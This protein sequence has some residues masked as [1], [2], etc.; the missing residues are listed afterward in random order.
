M[1]CS[2][3]LGEYVGTYLE[4]D[5][6]VHHF[7]PDL[8]NPDHLL[9][10][11]GSSIRVY[12]EV[13]LTTI[14]GSPSDFGYTEGFGNRKPKAM[15]NS[16]TSFVQLNQYE[17]VL[18]DRV[19]HCVRHVNRN[20]TRTRGF[21]GR[22]GS[23]GDV[24]GINARFWV[25]WGIFENV[26]NP[27]QLLVTDT[28][29]GGVK[30]IDKK[31]R[32]VGRLLQ[33]KRMNKPSGVLQTPNGIYISA[34]SGVHLF[35][36]GKLLLVT[37]TTSSKGFK[38]GLYNVARY[39]TLR[40]MIQLNKTTIMVADSNNHRVRV[41]DNSIRNVSS[42]CNGDQGHVDEQ[43]KTCSLTFV[44]SLLAHKNTLFIGEYQRI[45]RVQGMS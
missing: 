30:T 8:L 17:I 14:I 44:Y 28:G 43:L 21:A 36:K 38:D 23:R 24:E 19:N 37:G 18:V 34:E 45:R 12:D 41:L 15:F 11:D 26:N 16:I 2:V 42:I 7:E 9:I 13:K 35:L 27:K 3:L 20:D 33:S 29:N 39:D 22:C 6:N 31:T 25:P 40:A 10:A 4:T 1:H 32:M 5:G